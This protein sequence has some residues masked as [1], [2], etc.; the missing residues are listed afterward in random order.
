MSLKHT[1]WCNG[2]CENRSSVLICVIAL[3]YVNFVVEMCV[4][5]GKTGIPWVPWDSHGSGNKISHG[6]E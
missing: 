2:V 4:G 1:E 5:M 3:I 6:W